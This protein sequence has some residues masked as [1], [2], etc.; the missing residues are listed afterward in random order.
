MSFDM[1]KALAQA[2]REQKKRPPAL[3]RRVQ[4]MTNAYHD[5]CTGEDPWTALGNFTNAWYGYATHMREALVSEPIVK[6]EQETE[7]TRRLAAFCAASTENLC[8]L[9]NIPCQDWV[10]DP[11][12]NMTTPWCNI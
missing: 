2:Y 6:P 8:S 5:I 12:T 11:D 3:P 7:Y 9:Y 1:L 4:T 10:N